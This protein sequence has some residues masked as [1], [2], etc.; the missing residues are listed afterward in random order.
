MF[1]ARV[2]ALLQPQALNE[3]KGLATEIAENSTA[4]EFDKAGLPTPESLEPVT[5]R[6]ASKLLRDRFTLRLADAPFDRADADLVPGAGSC[7]DCP[8]RSGNQGELF[9]DVPSVDVCTDPTCFGAEEEGRGRGRGREAREEGGRSRRGPPEGLRGR[10]APPSG[11]VKLDEFC[12]EAGKT[13]GEVLKGK[14]VEKALGNRARTVMLDEKNKPVDLV[15][16]GALLD[17]AGLKGAG[18]WRES[19]RPA[20][21]GGQAGPG[22][23]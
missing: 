15:D 8:K 23:R 4:T 1:L 10:G 12:P 3:L 7:K 2:P 17:A 14:R 9:A 13:Y 21:V 6:E 5:A 22:R 20:E 11:M 18:A 16:K 19:L